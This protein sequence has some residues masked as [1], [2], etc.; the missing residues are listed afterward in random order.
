MAEP[1]WSWPDLHDA[2]RSVLLE[3]LVHGSHSRAELTR[4][5]GLSRASLMRLARNLVDLGLA[6]EGGTETRRSRGRPSG[7]LHLRGEAAHFIGIK[8]TG[9]ALYCAVTDLSARV[10]STSEK[11]FRSRS[12]DDVVDLIGH[13]V[14][15]MRRDHPRIAAIGVCLAGDITGADGEREVVGSHF[16]GWDAVPLVRLVAERT[17]LPTEIANDVQALTTAHHWF[18]AGRGSRSMALIGLGAGIGAGIVVDDDL[19]RGAGGRPGKVGHLR[20][21][22]SGPECDRGHVGCVSAYVTGPA[23]ERR[24]GAPVRAVV[25]RAADGDAG[26]TSILDD[27]VRALGVVIGTLVSIT[28]VEKVI[29]TGEGLPI[30]ARNPALLFASTAAALDPASAPPRVEMH[31]FEFSDYAWAAAVC[32]TR[33]LLSS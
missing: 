22:D 17:G 24:A 14:D 25:A 19:I 15:E 6:S 32:A 16:L 11:K 8:L 13:V 9:D 2:Q 20:V 28:D 23:I 4:R 5:T 10:V 12:V 3:L 18:G 1:S 33:L 26:C 21:H 29:V 30:I 27:A 7:T 31:P